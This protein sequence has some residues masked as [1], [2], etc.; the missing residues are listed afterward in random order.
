MEEGIWDKTEGQRVDGEG[1][2]YCIGCR[3]GLVVGL[4]GGQVDWGWVGQIYQRKLLS[5]VRLGGVTLGLK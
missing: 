5:N 1:C 3:W 4:A 2:E